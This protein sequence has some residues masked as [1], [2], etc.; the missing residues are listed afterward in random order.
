M[1]AI[2]SVY[3]KTGLVEFGLG[4]AALGVEIHSTGGTMKALAEAKVAVRSISDL[5]GFPEILDG[6]VKTLHPKVH[7]GI[8]ARR[9]LAAHQAQ[10]KAH[11]IAPIDLIAVNLYP[12]VS[13]VMKPGVSLDEGLENIDIGGPTM[14]RSAAKNFPHV[15]VLT[16][17]ADYGPIL[18]ELKAGA[19][20]Q[21][22][23]R[24]LAAKAFQHVSVYDAA[25]AAY[26]RGQEGGFPQELSFGLRKLQDLRYGENPHQQAAFYADVSPGVLVSHS[27]TWAQQ[28]HGKE[29]SYNNILDLDSALGAVWDF[30]GATICIVKHNNPC[31]LATHEQLSEAYKRAFAGDPVSAFGGIV[32]CNVPVDLETAEAM[33]PTFYEAVIAPGF[34]PAAL[35]R[36]KRKRDLRI[37]ATGPAVAPSPNARYLDLRRVRGGFLVQTPDAYPDDGIELKTGSQRAPTPAEVADLRYAWKIVKHIKS[38]AIVLARDRAL[39]GMGA[40][41]PNRVTSVRLAVERAGER[42]RGSVLASDAFFP[43]PDGVEA[44]AAAGVTAI[45]QPGG[46]IRDQEIIAAADKAGMAMVFT[47]VR[48]FKH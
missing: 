3:D 18:E 22:M 42:A 37:L 35:E 29:L 10:L 14:L 9:D 40:G 15:L 6:R 43:F 2:L 45:I 1:R 12:F 28:L 11:A 26:L 4:L 13:T 5:T 39:L 34:A 7:G 8:L 20:S 17:P 48:H 44:A 32:A 41:Q 23:R 30:S 31:G 25:V 46:S 19:V 21:E 24:R 27:V 47:G 38:N 16:D 33:A 36:L